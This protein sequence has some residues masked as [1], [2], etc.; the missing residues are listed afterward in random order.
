VKLPA[1]GAKNRRSFLID[2][3]SKSAQNASM[4]IVEDVRQVL[5]DFLAPELRTLNAKVDTLTTRVEAIESGLESIN[6]RLSALETSSKIRFETLEITTQ[7]RFDRAEEKAHARQDVILIQFESMRNQLNLDGRLRRIEDRDAS[8][9]LP[10]S[11]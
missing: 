5:Q 10:Q 3:N 11:A 7:S 2:L 4:S 8:H 9:T 1:I 6:T